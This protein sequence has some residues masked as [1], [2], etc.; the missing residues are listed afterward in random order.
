MNDIDLV[1]QIK[2]ENA[3][4]FQYLVSKYQRLVFH[5]VWR[6]NG[7]QADVED[8]SQDVFMKVFKSLKS[9]KG[10]S[11]LS[12]WIASI[13]YKTCADAHKKKRKNKVDVS[14]HIDVLESSSYNNI[15]DQVSGMDMKKIIQ[16]IV[17]KLPPNYQTV[18]SLHY[19]EEFSLVEIN[20][21][22]NMPIGTIKSNLSRARLMFKEIAGKLYGSEAMH[23]LLEDK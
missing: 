6:M 22:T 13:A 10:D 3:S 20:E 8:I 16:D 15:Q 14:E 19:F 23:L 5:V 4:A 9:F 18:L 2:N 1:K 21:I 17:S 12:T 11:K 7:N